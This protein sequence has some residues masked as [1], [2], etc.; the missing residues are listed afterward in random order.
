[1]ADPAGSLIR[2]AAAAVCLS[3]TCAARVFAQSPLPTPIDA[4][5][6]PD[7]LPRGSFHLS[8]AGLQIDDPQFT[9]DTHFGGE[10][11]VVDYV[12]GRVNVVIDYQAIL[13]S[14]F[15]IFDPNQGNYILET[16]TSGRIAGTEV[17]GVFHHESRHL[18]D[19]PKRFAIAWNWLGVRALRRID[20]SGTTF[21]VQGSAGKIT[22]HSYVDY[23]WTSDL[24]VVVRRPIN[25][26]VSV[27]AHGTGELFGIDS[28]LSARPT[29][30]DGRVEIGVRLTGPG[31]AIEAFA[32]FERRIDADPLDLQAPRWTFAGFRIIN[33]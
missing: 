23:A 14:E 3:F 10:V 18:S 17:A 32:G 5:A 11:D 1:M 7:F 25:P 4:P 9:W 12:F 13:G 29:Q 26:R 15:R 2:H 21:E 24:D 30:K 6:A 20:V 16:S 19:R 8:A 33:R 27:Y 28:S 22:Q 31:A